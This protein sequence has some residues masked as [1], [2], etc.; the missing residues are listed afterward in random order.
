[1]LRQ[2]ITH[3]MTRTHRHWCWSFDWLFQLIKLDDVSDYGDED[4]Q[5]I[6][7]GSYPHRYSKNR[8]LS[9]REIH[10]RQE[11]VKRR[12]EAIKEDYMNNHS[13]HILIFHKKI[14]TIVPI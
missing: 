14:N 8:I 6:I 11:A 10:A 9:S 13:N 1:M 4:G 12:R 7:F 5:A 2:Y 3:I